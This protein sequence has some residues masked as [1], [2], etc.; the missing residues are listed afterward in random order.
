M[1][2]LTYTIQKREYIKKLRDYNIKKS[3]K[4]KFEMKNVFIFQEKNYPTK[5]TKKKQQK[6][7]KRLHSQKG[8]ENP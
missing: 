4:N 2:I 5:I 8:R 6:K 1:I 3:I 7:D